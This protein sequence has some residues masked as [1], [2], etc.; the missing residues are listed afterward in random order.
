MHVLV[1]I[2][3][4]AG[5]VVEYAIDVEAWD[6]LGAGVYC[7]LRVIADELLRVKRS[8]QRS[9]QELVCTALTSKVPMIDGFA[10]KICNQWHLL[11]TFANWR[12]LILQLRL[13]N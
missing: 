8:K 6:V 5:P 7:I 2:P 11:A 9:G 13:Y 4:L 3:C 1:A 12:Q 10:L